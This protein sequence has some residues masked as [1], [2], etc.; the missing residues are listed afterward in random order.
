[1]V[2]NVYLVTNVSEPLGQF[3]TK[4]SSSG[5][6]IPICLNGGSKILNTVLLMSPVVATYTSARWVNSAWFRG[7]TARKR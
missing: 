7:R 6:S 3:S 5:D 2:T 4:A 1:M